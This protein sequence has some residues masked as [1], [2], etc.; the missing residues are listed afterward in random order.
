[1]QKEERSG[2]EEGQRMQGCVE[3]APDWSGEGTRAEER[4]T[5]TPGRTRTQEKDEVAAGEMKLGAARS[6][7]KSPPTRAARQGGGSKRRKGHGF[8]NLQQAAQ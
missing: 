4:P 1:M 8:P 3:Q 2:A 6:A 5:T 7:R